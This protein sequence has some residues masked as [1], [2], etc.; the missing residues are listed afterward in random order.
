VG[1]F[2]QAL[3]INL[4][5]LLF[6]PLKNELGLSYEQ[7]GRL[8][9]VNFAT[10][11]V[12]DV[13]C[14]ALVDRV[15]AKAFI[16]AS[17][18]LAV[19]GLW[20]FALTPGAFANPYNGLLLGTVV[21][22]MGGG[23]LELLLSPIVNAVPSERK[24][25]DMALLH[26]FYAVGQVVVVLVTTV[27]LHFAGVRSW[28]VVVLAWSVMPALNTIGFVVA[29]LPPLS[30]P[31]GRQRV[32]DLVRK[33][34]YLVSLLVLGLAG[35]TEIAIAQWTSAFAERA[36]GWPKVVGDLVGFCLFGVGLGVGRIWY[37]IKGERIDLRR[38]MILGGGLA[39]LTY[40]VAGVSPWPL[41]SLAACA[42][43]G[44]TVSLLWPG[45]LSLT[46]ARFPLAG[47]SL[48]ALLA[49]SGDTG[50]AV[51]PWLVGVIAD[52]APNLGGPLSRLAERIGADQLGLRAGLVAA[53]LCPIVMTALL[54]WLR[55]EH[56]RHSRPPAM[57]P[58]VARSTGSSV[59]RSSEIPSPRRS[60]CAAL[61]KVSQI[62]PSS[63]ATAAYTAS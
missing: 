54:V 25:A 38:M 22:S 20:L 36:L 14:G 61:S 21:F 10:Q 58:Q 34:V 17:N 1:A 55:G 44:L 50:A 24:A 27:V 5:P 56:G 2:I 8:I 7:I 57:A 32:R 37:G 59:A 18:V 63:R 41:V 6:I 43:A 48:F 46:A 42:C 35:A 51:M 45:T 62:A 26:S 31:Q 40:V 39:A 11:M 12:M 49:A 9:L 3:V 15:G 13:G 19:F 47:A 4:T 16:V 60:L 23:L 33:P 28:R 29:R 53:S 52:A 30:P